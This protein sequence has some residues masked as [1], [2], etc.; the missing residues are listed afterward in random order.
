M[1]QLGFG[2]STWGVGVEYF[3][4]VQVVCGARE[5]LHFKPFGCY[6]TILN[7]SDH[8]GKFDGKADKGYIV[9]YSANTDSDSDYDEQVIIVLSYQ[10]LS[11]HRSKTK[12]TSSTPVDDSLFPS[13]DKIFQKELAKLKVPT[14]SIPVPTGSLLVPTGGIQVPAEATMD[15]TDD[16]SIHTSSLT[17]SILNGEPTTRFPCLSDIGN[18]VPS[19]SIFS[20]PSYDDEFGT[21]IR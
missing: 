15:T 21:Y 6:V 5:R 2:T 14:G 13:A 1:C 8:L 11:I 4:T 7:T 16:V 3:G 18:H 17:D 12:A 9:G 10:S 20:S 19:P